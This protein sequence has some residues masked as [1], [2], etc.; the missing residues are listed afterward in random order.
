MEEVVFRTSGVCSKEIKLQLEDNIVVKAEFLN[1]CDGNLSGIGRL[2]EG[3]DA[4]E[5]IRKLEGITCGKKQT[6]C[7]DQLATALKIKLGK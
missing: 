4:N 3:M 2:I 7:P 1:G 5:V 6:S